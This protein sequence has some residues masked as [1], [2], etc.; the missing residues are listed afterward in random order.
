MPRKNDA[1]N[2]NSYYSSKSYPPSP[3]LQ[4]PTPLPDEHVPIMSHSALY[5]SRTEEPG[6]L[7]PLI[8]FDTPTPPQPIVSLP[9]ET[10]LVLGSDIDSDIAIGRSPPFREAPLPQDSPPPLPI[11]PRVAYWTDQ[12]YQ[13]SMEGTLVTDERSFVGHSRTPNFSR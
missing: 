5:L 11:R 10:S 6:V 13:R 2:K 8:D 7:S 4:L 1:Q 3:P 9:A 12:E